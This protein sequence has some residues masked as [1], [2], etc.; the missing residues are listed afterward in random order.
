MSELEQLRRHYPEAAY[1]DALEAAARERAL[2]ALR[3]R[4]EAPGR[5]GPG[6]DGRRRFAPR[7]RRRLA[8]A[9]AGATA[10]AAVAGAVFLGSD[11]PGG[12]T[13]SAA[14]AVLR[15]AAEAA[16][17]EPVLAV[18]GDG[19]YLYVRRVEAYLSESDLG[20]R[21]LEPRLRETWLSRDGGR[22]RTTFRR[23]IFLTPADRRHWESLG[24]PTPGE[25]GRTVD[26]DVPPPDQLG[27]PSDPDELFDRLHDRARGH[28]EGTYRQMFGLVRDGLIDVS[29][30]TGQRAALYEVAA[31]I[32]GVQLIGRVRDRSGRP[33]V[34]VAMPNPPDGRRETLIFDPDTGA[35][36]AEEQVALPGSGYPAGKPIAYATYA[37]SIVD[38]VGER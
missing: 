18:P 7:P 23:G 21:V 14:T 11:T 28:S 32:P 6:S 30:T 34:A 16:R 5:P 29:A 33:G 10:A 12:A 25:P 38:A 2:A 31:R 9:L 3:A 35:F 36:L 26:V 24:L 17:S 19:R 4:I 13:A 22:E 20:T 27:L 8:L 37:T 15:D 1:D